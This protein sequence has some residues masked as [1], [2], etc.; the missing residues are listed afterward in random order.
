M[1]VLSGPDLEPWNNVIAALALVGVIIVMV[2]IA[3]RILSANQE[4]K[5]NA[6]QNSKQGDPD[7]TASL[8]V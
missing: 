5:E 8:A 3:V 4:D 1:P 7:Q 2:W 6:C